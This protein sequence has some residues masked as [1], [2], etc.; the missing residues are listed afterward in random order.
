VSSQAV[1]LPSFALDKQ[2]LDTPGHCDRMCSS[3]LGSRLDR[4][5]RE[6]S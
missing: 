2:S 5:S 4:D 3:L 1:D 6:I